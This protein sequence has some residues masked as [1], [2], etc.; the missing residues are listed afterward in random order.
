MKRLLLVSVLV[1]ATT[2]P[3]TALAGGGTMEDGDSKLARGAPLDWIGPVEAGGLVGFNVKKTN[4]GKKVTRFAWGDGVPMTCND[5]AQATSG[6]L[7]FGM[8]VK[9]GEFRATAVSEGAT[10]TARVAG[11]FVK[12]RKAKGTLKVQGAVV[13]DDGVTHTGCNTGKLDWKA[14]KGGGSM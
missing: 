2:V 4:R 9:Q 8:K 5:G 14:F 10:A 13:G 7:T 6:H 1:L 3:A 11:K 12:K